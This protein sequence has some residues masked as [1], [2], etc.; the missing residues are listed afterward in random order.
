MFVVAH[1]SLVV[2]VVVLIVGVA[3]FVLF[4][5]LSVVC[6]LRAFAVAV[7]CCVGVCCLV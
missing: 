7:V 2:G 3:R 6:S 5:V 1:W 4:H